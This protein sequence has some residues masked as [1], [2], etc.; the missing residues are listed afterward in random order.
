MLD[1]YTI[2]HMSVAAIHN[3]ACLE[4]SG[5]L[6]DPR[7]GATRGWCVHAAPRIPAPTVDV[8]VRRAAR[9]ITTIPSFKQ[10]GRTKMV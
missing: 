2:F 8:R 1:A 5:C 10:G 4:Q 7:M 6:N 9:S 3:P